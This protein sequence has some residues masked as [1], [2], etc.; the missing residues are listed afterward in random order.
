MN[1]KI[2]NGAYL[3]MYDIEIKFSCLFTGT[4]YRGGD[5]KSFI[6]DLIRPGP[7]MW[8][9]EIPWILFKTIIIYWKFRPAETETSIKNLIK[10][11][12]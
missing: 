7:C 10:T 9:Y 6:L 3:E 11:I 5:R 2:E 12:F 1:W 4:S 8:F